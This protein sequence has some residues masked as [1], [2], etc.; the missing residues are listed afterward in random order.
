V[1]K[2]WKRPG[3]NTVEVAARQGARARSYWE[4]R[5][6][7]HPRGKNN[8]LDFFPTPQFVTEALPRR[9]RFYGTVLE[10]ASGNGTMVAVLKRHGYRVADA[11]ITKRPEAVF[12]KD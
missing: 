10:P 12:D 8:P 6:D 1:R 5:R 3:N 7:G 9:E 4:E 2:K 11:D